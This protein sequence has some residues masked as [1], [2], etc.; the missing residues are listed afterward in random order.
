MRAACAN[1]CDRGPERGCWEVAAPRDHGKNDC[2]VQGL[3][4]VRVSLRNPTY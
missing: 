4:K 2:N 1:E 3:T